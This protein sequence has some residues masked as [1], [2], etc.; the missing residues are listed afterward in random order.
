MS[1]VEQQSSLLTCDY[2]ISKGNFYSNTPL[3]QI[4]SAG[5][6]F[7]PFM[8]PIDK[9][10]FRF[11]YKIPSDL[12]F[13]A[14]GIFYLL[15]FDLVSL[16]TAP[17]LILPPPKLFQET[18]IFAALVTKFSYSVRAVLPSLGDSTKL[19]YTGLNSF[20]F[21]YNIYLWSIWTPE[22]ISFKEW[23][24][25]VSLNSFIYPG[26]TLLLRWLKWLYLVAS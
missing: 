23:P 25:P 2:L 4:F 7:T 11:W 26:A 14:N 10:R 24:M 18:P 1:L 16:E 5:S 21:E 13:W 3:E 22:S 9:T 19:L 12:A 17:G 8:S 6:P 15:A 20:C